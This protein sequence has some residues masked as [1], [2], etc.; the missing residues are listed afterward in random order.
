LVRVHSF[1]GGGA[2]TLALLTGC[3]G[4]TTVTDPAVALPTLTRDSLRAGFTVAPRL[5]ITPANEN[6]CESRAVQ[7]DAGD[8]FVRW[9]PTVTEQVT[10]TRG[11]ADTVL[12]RYELYAFNPRGKQTG[13][14]QCVLRRGTAATTFMRG[15]FA[16]PG[17]P[18]MVGV[19]AAQTATPVPDGVPRCSLARVARAC[20]T[21][22]AGRCSAATPRAIRS[23]RSGC[24]R[25]RSAS[26]W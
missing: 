19:L 24:R 17:R 8:R 11:A 20:W 3:A 13:E 10:V 16:R 25:A 2:L 12:T 5:A 26:G 7:R 23:S 1:R 22:G 21:C 4:E 6:R 18:G 9:R 15:F 14:A